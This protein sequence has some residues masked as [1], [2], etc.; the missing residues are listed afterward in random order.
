MTV[1]DT[2]AKLKALKTESEIS[3]DHNGEVY[4][5]KIRSMSGKTMAKFAAIEGL[6]TIMGQKEGEG[7]ALGALYPMFQVVIPA[8]CVEP[9]LTAEEQPQGEQVPI[10]FLPFDLLSKLFEEI[11]KFSELAENKETED[12]I[13][14]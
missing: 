3:I 9:Q 14:K 13:K 2:L 7:K 6:D 5:F 4:E 10:D 12:V 11:M 1:G 8:C